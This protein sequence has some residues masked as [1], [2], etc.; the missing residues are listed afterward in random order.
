M[1]SNGDEENDDRTLYSVELGWDEHPVGFGISENEHDSLNPGICEKTDESER[2]CTVRSSNF[3]TEQ[4]NAGFE[5]GRM[6][7]VDLNNPNKPV[8]NK[9][10]VVTDK[11]GIAFIGRQIYP[12]ISTIPFSEEII[13]RKIS[14]NEINEHSNANPCYSFQHANALNRKVEKIKGSYG[15]LFHKN[16]ERRD[17]DIDDVSGDAYIKNMRSKTDREETYQRGGKSSKRH[18]SEILERTDIEEITEPQ[19]TLN[20]NI[21]QSNGTYLKESYDGNN[22]EAGVNDGERHGHIDSLF[23]IKSMT[24]S[25]YEGIL[26][27]MKM[28]RIYRDQL[29]NRKGYKYKTEF[30][31]RVLNDIL[32]VTPY[33]NAEVLDAVGI[34]LNLKPRS[35]QIW[36]QNARQGGETQMTREELKGMRRNSSIDTQQIF[37]IYMRNRNRKTSNIE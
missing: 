17:I 16:T 14:R 13:K 2:K 12:H 18:S 5:D 9:N 15:I 26:G 11:K 29:Y 7:C 22:I 6:C 23:G 4:V 10:P 36:F 30:Q 37:E 1:K 33:P 27:I 19:A 35:V 28:K 20:D 24:M 34:L 21:D 3:Q 8:S 31:V 25:E 32:R